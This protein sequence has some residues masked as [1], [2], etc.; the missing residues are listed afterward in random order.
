[1]MRIEHGKYVRQYPAKKGTFDCDP[2]SNVTIKAD[3]IG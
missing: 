2:K 3:Y 1:M